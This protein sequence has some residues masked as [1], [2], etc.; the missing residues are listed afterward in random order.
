M[1]IVTQSAYGDR[2]HLDRIAEIVAAQ[3]ARDSDRA[4]FAELFTVMRGRL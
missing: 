2:A 1:T 4:Q 3:A